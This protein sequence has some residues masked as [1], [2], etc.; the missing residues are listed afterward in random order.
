MRRSHLRSEGPENGMNP[1]Y[2]QTKTDRSELEEILSCTDD[3]A[4]KAAWM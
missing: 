3:L 2:G 4:L 1:A